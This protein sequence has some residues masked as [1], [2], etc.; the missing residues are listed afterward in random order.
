MNSELL[1]AIVSNEQLE[2]DLKQA[3]TIAVHSKC[4]NGKPINGLNNCFFVTT[5]SWYVDLQADL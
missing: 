5:S 1:V 2:S 4:S 3:W